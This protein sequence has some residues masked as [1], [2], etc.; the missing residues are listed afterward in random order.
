MQFLHHPLVGDERYTGRRRSRLDA[1][2]CSR[3]F[4]HA[5][6]VTFSLPEEGSAEKRVTVE[7]PLAGDLQMSLEMLSI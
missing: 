7:A 2:W 4:L 3:Q 6:S 5:A 1:L